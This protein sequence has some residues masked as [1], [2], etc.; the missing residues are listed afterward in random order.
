MAS[1]GRPRHGL[2]GGPRGRRPVRRARLGPHPGW[3]VTCSAAE[4]NL[5]AYNGGVTNTVTLTADGRTCCRPRPSRRT[6]TRRSNSPS[7]T[8][9]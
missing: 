1:A 8:A 6:S 2:G 4:I 7:T 3:N 9:R 5:T